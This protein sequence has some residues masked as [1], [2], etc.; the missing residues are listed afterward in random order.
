[1]LCALVRMGVQGETHTARRINSWQYELSA[2]A[3]AEAQRGNSYAKGLSY[4]RTDEDCKSIRN[5]ML[6]N[7]NGKGTQRSDKFKK[8]QS[9]MM[10]GNKNGK[11][12]KGSIRL[13]SSLIGNQRSKGYKH[14][15][16]FGER[17]RARMLGNTYSLGKNTGGSHYKARKVICKNDSMVFPAIVEAA[18]FYGVTPKQIRRSCRYSNKSINGLFFKFA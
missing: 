7:T 6:G 12:N 13:I 4:K 15:K 8:E 1:M 9:E 17:T 3:N 10:L 11:G 2:K 14:P 16:E 18:K 5:R